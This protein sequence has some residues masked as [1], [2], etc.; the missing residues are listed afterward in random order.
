LRAIADTIE[1][2]D[3]RLVVEGRLREPRL[4]LGDEAP[5]R[6]DM[7]RFADALCAALRGERIALI[8]TL[9]DSV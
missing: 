8:R 5:Q 9:E 3:R 6:P 1:D 4:T 2:F 7:S